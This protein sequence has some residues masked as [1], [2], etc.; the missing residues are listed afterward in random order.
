M[1][2]AK[3]QTTMNTARVTIFRQVVQ[4]KKKTQDNNHLTFK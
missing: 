1:S 2:W 4:V 3:F